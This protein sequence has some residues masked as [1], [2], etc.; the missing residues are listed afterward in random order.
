MGWR[1]CLPAYRC[2]S[3]R[4]GSCR[5]SRPDEARQAFDCGM[6]LLAQSIEETQQLIA[7]MRPA[8]LDQYGV[9]AAI[10]GLVDQVR[11]HGGPE[12]VFES[13]LRC[14]HLEPAV[15][16]AVFRI[17][18]EAVNNA[19]HHSKTEQVRIDLSRRK[20]GDLHV[21]IRD[22]GIGFD[23]NSARDGSHG[24]SSMRERARLLGGQIVIDT[25]PGRG[26]LIDVDLPLKNGH[27]AR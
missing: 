23:V 22:W 14:D 16:H 20:S 2:T 17:V 15:Q 19:C 25:A 6:H 9:K 12:I 1:S 13:R 27:A 5:T 26:T 21:T 11:R 3:R 18:Q 24:L 4:I 8:T 7:G 10:Q